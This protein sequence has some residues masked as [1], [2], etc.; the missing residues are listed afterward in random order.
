VQGNQAAE[1]IFII[2][3]KQNHIK[4]S[5]HKAWTQPGVARVEAA[6]YN[7]LPL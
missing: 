4:G 3:P 5:V 2:V 1:V 6:N 7:F